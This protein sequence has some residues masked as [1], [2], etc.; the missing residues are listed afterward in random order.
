[1]GVGRREWGSAVVLTSSVRL[2]SISI[3]SHLVIV[4]MGEA[5]TQAPSTP[6]AG[7][8]FLPLLLSSRVPWGS[9]LNFLLQDGGM[10][11]VSF[12]S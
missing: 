8:Q 4:D 2:T 3:N 5:Q 7:V 10:M 1:M 12:V 9:L 6:P 11:T